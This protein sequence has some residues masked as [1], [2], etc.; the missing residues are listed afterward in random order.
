VGFKGSGFERLRQA[1]QTGLFEWGGGCVAH[2]GL[3]K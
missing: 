2:K 1:V 3:D